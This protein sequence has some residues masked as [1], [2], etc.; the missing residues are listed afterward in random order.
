[1][2]HRRKQLIAIAALTYLWPGAATAQ[3]G[4]FELGVQVTSMASS[5]FHRSDAGVGGRFAWHPGPLLGAEAEINFYPRNF[6]D[7][8]PFSRSRVQRPHG[9]SKGVFQP[10]LP[11]RRGRRLEVYV[12]AQAWGDGVPLVARLFTADTW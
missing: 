3:S 5:E 6:P 2:K 8:T 12:V 10:R 7:R 11:L 1:V 9:A 4:R